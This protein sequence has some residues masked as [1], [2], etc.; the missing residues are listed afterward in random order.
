VERGVPFKNLLDYLECGDTL[1][2]ILDDFPSVTYEAA[3]AGWSSGDHRSGN[4][5]SAESRGPKHSHAR[6]RGGIQSDRGK[7]CLAP[8]G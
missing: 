1:Q 4:G 8:F 3:I 2:K 6:D 7:N 5:A